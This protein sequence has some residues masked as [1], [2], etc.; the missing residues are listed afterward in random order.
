VHAFSVSGGQSVRSMS[1]TTGTA[2]RGEKRRL[3]LVEA[4]PADSALQATALEAAGFDVSVVSTGDRLPDIVERGRPAVVVIDLAAGGADPFD[5]LAAIHALEPPVATIATTADTSLNTAI[6]AV[7]AGARDCLVKPFKPERLVSAVRRAL[8]PEPTELDRRAAAVERRPDG[9]IGSSP[10]MQAVY[11][12]ISTAAASKAAVFITGESGT[13]KEICAQAIHRAGSRKDKPFVA[14]NCSAMPRDLIEAELFG[15]V[16][17]AFTGA[18]SNRAGAAL[19]AQGGTLFLDEICEMD[20]TLQAK[21]LRFLQT[22][23]VQRVGSCAAEDVDVRIVCA[24]NRDPL[25]EIAAGR[26]REDLYYRLHVIPIH[27]LPLRER[28]ADILEIARILLLEIV[29]EEG[30]PVR[31]LAPDAEAAILRYPW[32][33]NVRQ[34]QNVLRSMVIFSDQEELTA[35]ALPEP[36]RAAAAQPAAPWEAPTTARG[37]PSPVTVAG[38]ARTADTGP[39]APGHGD[40]I[41]PLWRVEKRAIENAIRLYGDNIARAA[42]ALEIS[43]STIYRKRQAWATEGGMRTVAEYFVTGQR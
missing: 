35:G 2:S 23:T 38:S 37:W 43:P 3:V 18:V 36:I 13:G 1:S 20:V 28:G 19:Q 24:T 30:R 11:Q 33:G 10:Q 14:V 31:R 39:V 41:E 26:F 29:R 4:A 9:F 32:P 5:L 22:G 25:A 6:K 16:K 12:I 8:G 40:V 15:H 42:A 21:L 27:L 34:L 17:G 7:R